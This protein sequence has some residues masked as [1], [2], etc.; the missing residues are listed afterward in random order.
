MRQSHIIE[1][2]GVFVGTAACYVDG[3]GYRFVGIHQRLKTMD[4]QFFPDLD[5]VRTHVALTYRRTRIEAN[6]LAPAA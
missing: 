4:G 2:D 5:A 6:R 1:V 3:A